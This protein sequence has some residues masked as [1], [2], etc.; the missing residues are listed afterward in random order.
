MHTHKDELPPWEDLYKKSTVESLPW[1]NPELDDDLQS[2][3]EELQLKK[4]KALDLGTGPGTQAVRLARAGFDVTATDVS[5]DAIRLAREKMAQTAGPLVR[6]QKDNILETMLDEQFD[7]IFD[8]GCFHVFARGSRPEYVKTVYDLLR[9]GGYLFLKCF[10]H[11]QPGEWGPNRFTPQQIRDIFG[12]KLKII[13]IK[14]TRFKGTMDLDPKALFC[15]MQKT[16]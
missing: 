5:R 3:L 12:Q 11:L 7:F 16:E 9:P 6:W 14:E 13:S 1:Y 8:R 4:G 2:V 10:S 15:V